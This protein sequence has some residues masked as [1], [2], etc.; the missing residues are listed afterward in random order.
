MWM[1]MS[2][3]ACA[4]VVNAMTLAT[5]D[6]YAQ[7]ES[8][9]PKEANQQKPTEQKQGGQYSGFENTGNQSYGIPRSGGN[10]TPQAPITGQNVQI[11][12]KTTSTAGISST[13]TL[14]SPSGIAMIAGM[15]G[16]AAVAIGAGVWYFRKKSSNT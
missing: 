1:W 6:V 16:A 8:A 10:P 5:S 7:N 9:P 4:L 12:N 2:L 13:E 11:E 3:L 14:E 15:G